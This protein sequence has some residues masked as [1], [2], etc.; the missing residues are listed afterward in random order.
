MEEQ[1]QL[2]VQRAKAI[3]AL[4]TLETRPALFLLDYTFKGKAGKV[5]LF[6]EG[7]A[8]NGE[9]LY[10][11]SDL[12]PM[13]VAQL[14]KYMGIRNV[15]LIPVDPSE[16]RAHVQKNPRAKWVPVPI[17]KSDFNDHEVKP[18]DAARK[19]GILSAHTPKLSNLETI[20]EDLSLLAKYYRDQSVNYCARFGITGVLYAVAKEKNKISPVGSVDARDMLRNYGQDRNRGLFEV[21][22]LAKIRKE[23]GKDEMYETIKNAP[24]GSLITVSPGMANIHAGHLIASLGNGE[25]MEIRDKKIRTID[26]EKVKGYPIVYES[27]IYIPNFSNPA[28]QDGLLMNVSPHVVYDI[29]KDKVSSKMKDPQT[30]ASDVSNYLLHKFDINVNP[31]SILLD[32]LAQNRLNPGDYNKKI[33]LSEM[34]VEILLPGKMFGLFSEKR[35]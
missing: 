30:Y 11:R 9:Q 5:F 33:S 34:S 10:G 28:F 13:T 24:A 31:A 15:N 35:S 8:A 25:F 22:N 16:L 2:N 21:K 27:R 3:K 18:G 29:S 7:T 23:N 6:S 32:I 12:R 26:L 14:T 20:K 19:I 4:E 1:A 17:L